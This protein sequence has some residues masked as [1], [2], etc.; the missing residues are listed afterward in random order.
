MTIYVII[1]RLTHKKNDP[2][3]IIN[4]KESSKKII[5]DGKR[6]QNMTK[7]SFWDFD[8]ISRISHNMVWILH[9]QEHIKNIHRQMLWKCFADFIQIA[10]F[11]EN[12]Q[13]FKNLITSN[14]YFYKDNNKIYKFIT[15]LGYIDFFMSFL[16]YIYVYLWSLDTY[17]FMPSYPRNKSG[18]IWDN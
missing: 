11:R 3:V 17:S 15:S 7:Y 5:L 13:S 10:I 16:W 1:N 9:V 18:R 8:F 6:N 12:R 4:T 14:N 2:S